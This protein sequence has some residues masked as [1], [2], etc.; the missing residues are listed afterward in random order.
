MS[1]FNTQHLHFLFSFSPHAI[2]KLSPSFMSSFPHFG[3]F[4]SLTLLSLLV[5]FESYPHFPHLTQY[6]V[7]KHTFFTLYSI[8]ILTRLYISSILLLEA[9]KI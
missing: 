5:L 6:F 4:I 3:H 8:L 7:Y 9:S 2:Q 1:F